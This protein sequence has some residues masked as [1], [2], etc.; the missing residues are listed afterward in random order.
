MVI[1]FKRPSIKD[2]KD[3]ILIKY[4]ELLNAYKENT[5]KLELVQDDDGKPIK[6]VKLSSRDIVESLSELK[7]T[8]DDTLNGIEASFLKKL[9]ELDEANE[10]LNE[11]KR[12]LKINHDLVAEANSVDALI[13]AQ[14]KIADE[15]REEM[16]TI[17]L[18]WKREQEEYNYDWQI[19]KAHMEDELVKTR[20]KFNAELEA[21]RND[22]D[23]EIESYKEI[24]ELREKEIAKLNEILDKERDSHLQ[25]IANLKQTIIRETNDKYKYEYETKLQILETKNE[26]LISKVT[27]LREENVILHNQLSEANERAS[28]IAAKAVESSKV[29]HVRDKE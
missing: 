15:F 14:D 28:N 12:E 4:D 7:L 25:E 20:N 6:K 16:D 2:T 13:E 11:I 5:R 23:K 24:A 10:Q 26:G 8:L 17:K 29:I 22:I 21:S 27:E 9:K 1:Q 3:K 19:R 18:Q